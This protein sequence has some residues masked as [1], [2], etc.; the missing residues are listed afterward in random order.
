MQMVF[1]RFYHGISALQ[2]AL[3]CTSAKGTANT[4]GMRSEISEEFSIDYNCSC[5][6]LP[7]IK[8]FGGMFYS[9]EESHIEGAKN[10]KHHLICPPWSILLLPEIGALLSISFASA[11]C[12]A[13]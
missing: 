7:S 2:T 12:N 3:Y 4:A 1:F 13:K 5:S 8:S 11:T 9:E 6:P 10:Q